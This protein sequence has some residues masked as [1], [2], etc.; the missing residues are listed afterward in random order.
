MSRSRRT[1]PAELKTRVALDGLPGVRTLS[2]L[3]SKYGVHPNQIS[4]W[5]Q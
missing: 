4:Q 2:K 3:A 1:F 5:K